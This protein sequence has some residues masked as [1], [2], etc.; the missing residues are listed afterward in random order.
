MERLIVYAYWPW[1]AKFPRFRKAGLDKQK[2]AL[3]ISSSAAPGFLGRLMY[4]TG[5]QLKTT[6]QTIGAVPVG[7][8]FTGMIGDDLKHGIPARVEAKARYMA[9][10]LLD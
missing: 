3:L 6:A 8:L 4:N 1:E 9:G 10:L 2:T 7:S 5:K